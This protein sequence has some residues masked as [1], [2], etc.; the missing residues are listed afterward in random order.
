M[1]VMP[2]SLVPDRRPTDPYFKITLCLIPAH[3][4]PPR[5]I[6]H[7][8]YPSVLIPSRLI[9]VT[10]DTRTFDIR[11]VWYPPRLIPTT[12]DTRAFDIHHVW[13][14]SRLIPTRLI[15]SCLIPARLIPAMFDTCHVWHPPVWYPTHLISSHSKNSGFGL[16]YFNYYR[17]IVEMGPGIP[18][19]GTRPGMPEKMPA[20]ARPSLYK[21][22]RACLCPPDARTIAR[23][24]ALG[25]NI[26]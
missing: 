19:P 15:P 8:R 7:V 14:P 6:P 17:Y 23:G 4:I 26:K 3:L 22:I 21:K 25:Q 11:H 18:V 12:F 20:R 10:F 2:R 9:P 16:N 1:V 24:H 13:Y 5:L